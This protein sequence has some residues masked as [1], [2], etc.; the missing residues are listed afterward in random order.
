MIAIDCCFCGGVDLEPGGFSSG[1][2][3]KTNPVLMRGDLRNQNWTDINREPHSADPT[4][5]F[6]PGKVDVLPA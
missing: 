1:C 4:I 2:F 6:L 3:S 5:R